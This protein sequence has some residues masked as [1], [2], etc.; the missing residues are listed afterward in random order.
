MGCYEVSLGDTLGVGSPRQVRHLLKY[1]LDNGIP[2]ERLAGHFHDTYGQA[3]ANVWEAY[4][5]GIRV[6]DSSVAGLGGCPFAPGAKGNVATEDVVY[7]FQRAGVDTGVDLTRLVEVGAWISEQLKKPN[8]SRAGTALAK[9]TNS[10]NKQVSDDSKSTPANAVSWQ[11]VKESDGLLVHRSGVN[12]KLTM[13]R[14]KKGNILTTS[15]I[16][17]LTSEFSR[18][19]EDPTISRVV[20]TGEGKYFCTGMDL[21]KD[22][23]AV[24][25]G[26]DASDAQFN[27]LYGLF[28]A[29]DRCPKVT[30]ACIN[31]PAFG[32][33]VGLAFACDIRLVSRTAGITLSEV[34][35]GICAA[36]ISKYIV[37]EW[38]VA[39]AR[40][41]M[42]TA[43]TVS[44]DELQRKGI[45]MSV[46][47]DTEGLRRLLDSTLM[48]LRIA[49]P[50]GSR[51]SKDLVRL[52]WANAGQEG[53]DHGIKQTF[54]AMMQPGTDGAFGVREFQAGRK[55]DWDERGMGKTPSKL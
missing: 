7:M 36:T 45:I 33:G 29:I 54:D 32:G 51:M 4:N 30:I 42:L 6:F 47:D 48:N 15:M 49:S 38:G 12:L 28:E 31:G 3:L 27:Q 53:Q 39:F 24:G 22:K 35:L 55:V 50:A 10:R 26:G 20:L 1:L 8:G 25:S 34:K 21:S 13:N 37:R 17:D 23:T 9:K 11:L 46:A 44:P 41:A 16:Y 19:G 52:G 18:A 43:R 5:C 2:A 14:P 40:E